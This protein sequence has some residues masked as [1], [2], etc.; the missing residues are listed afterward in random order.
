MR[1]INTFVALVPVV[2]LIGL[3]AVNIMVFGNDALSGASQLVM[4]FSAAVATLIALRLGASWKTLHEGIINSIR[5][6]TPAILIL[7]MVGALSGTWLVGGVVP[8]MIY[9]GMYVLSPGIFLFASCIVCILVSLFTGSSWTTSATVGIALMGISQGL[10]IDLGMT[11]GAILSGAYFGDK[12]SPL[13]D[14]TNLAAG[15]AE[16][17][18]FTHIRYMLYTTVPSISIAL[19]VFLVLGFGGDGGNTD[20]GQISSVLSGQFNINAW[21]LIAPAAV[22]FMILK[23]VPALPAIFVGAVIGAI[24]ALIFQ[25]PLLQ[26]LAAQTG[27]TGYAVILNTFFGE[28]SIVTG[29]EVLDGLLSSG[30][31]AGMLNTIWLILSA[32]M[33]GGVMEGSG[34]LKVITRSLIHRAKSIAQLFVA[35]TGTC[36]FT[37]V[38]ASDQYLSVIVPGQMFKSA[39]RDH[40]LA[41]QNLSRTLEDSGTVTSVLV[42]WNTCGAYHA[43]VLGVATL[44]YAPFAVFCFVSPL[45]TLLYARLEIR[46]ARLS[47]DSISE[48]DADSKPDTANA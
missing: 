30:G 36:I 28:T 11:A 42:P 13:S 23:K 40:K 21:L 44:S 14:T 35:T 38:S 1:P 48:S 15:I 8:A 27:T 18:L 4:I 22:I 19:L 26:S 34:F 2:L 47:E 29:N 20:T 43:T 7:L 25:Q 33:F 46:L 32:M 37:N 24:L 41:P 3:L 16:T 17:E 45:M 5:V 6:A 12:L 39:Y 10:G 9:Y 31:M